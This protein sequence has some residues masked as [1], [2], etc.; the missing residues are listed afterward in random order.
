MYSNDDSL[1]TLKRCTHIKTRYSNYDNVL[2]LQQYTHTK[3][4]Y[5]H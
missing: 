5:S 1:L 3:K 2:T 4:M